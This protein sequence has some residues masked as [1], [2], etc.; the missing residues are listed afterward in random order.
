MCCARLQREHEGDPV[1]ALL[2]EIK[3]EDA[4]GAAQRWLTHAMGGKPYTPPVLLLLSEIKARHGTLTEFWRVI[5]ELRPLLV[6]E[7]T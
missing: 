6:A 3:F 1:S 4:P 2:G 7:T 5:C